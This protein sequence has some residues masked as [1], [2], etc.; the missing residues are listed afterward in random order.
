MTS[1]RSLTLSVVTVLCAAAMV[2]R[3]VTTTQ[4]AAAAADPALIAYADAN[5]G[6]SLVEPGH[7]RT[8][9]RIAGSAGAESP[10]WAPNGKRLAFVVPGASNAATI[11]LVDRAGGNVKTLLSGASAGVDGAIAWS[12]DGREIAYACYGAEKEAT[13]YVDQLCVL[14]LSSGSHSQITSTP[15]DGLSQTSEGFQR[16]SW[17]PDGAQIAATVDH[18]VACDPSAPDGTYCHRSDVG[19]IDA[20]TGSYHLLTNNYALEP[21]FSPNG[22]HIVYYDPS[23][24]HGEPT[25]VVTMDAEGKHPRTIVPETTVRGGLEDVEA[26]PIYSP[27]GKQILYAGAGAGNGQTAAQLFAVPAAGGH[28]AQWTRNAEAAFDPTWTPQ[29]TTCTVP[30]L[31]GKK[32]TKAKRLI[33]KAHCRLGHITGP[34]HHRGRLHVVKQ[35]P[36]PHKERPA[37]S[38]VKVTLG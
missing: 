11:K 17:S 5:H 15:S 31:I 19:L 14:H 27:N 37:G 36:K 7:P 6:I 18:Q 33:A 12:P 8:Q 1:G 32:F 24:T 13:V 29:R 22:A 21:S 30:K 3:V 4:P 34:K 28:S 2:G 10:A 16:L 25:G 9:R 26:D 23:A 38:K 20:K 35:S